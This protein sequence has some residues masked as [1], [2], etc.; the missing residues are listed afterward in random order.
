MKSLAKRFL[1][2]AALGAAIAVSA[3][4]ANAELSFSIGIGGPV[5]YG[6]DYWRPCGWYFDHG[7][8]APYRCYD[9]YRG[10]W[11]SRLYVSDGFVFRDRDDWNRWRGRDDFRRWRGHEW[12]HDRRDWDRG[13]PGWDRGDHDWHHDDRGHDRGD[14]GRGDHRGDRGHDRG[15]RDHH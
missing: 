4:A 1:I 14:R 11:G 2:G 6:Y 13:H 5:Y 8:P 7:F 12:D 3:P 9:Y 15:D 10:S